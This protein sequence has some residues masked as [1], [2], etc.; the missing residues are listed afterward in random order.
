MHILFVHSDGFIIK[1]F[2]FLLP[3]HRWCGGGGKCGGKWAF[4]DVCE[5]IQVEKKVLPLYTFSRRKAERET[6]THALPLIPACKAV[7]RP[8]MAPGPET[9]G[10]EEKID[11][12]KRYWIFG[13]THNNADF[14]YSANTF[15]SILQLISHINSETLTWLWFIVRTWC[16]YCLCVFKPFHSFALFKA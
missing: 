4:R 16:Y 15:V 13:E 2:D 9:E 3:S 7:P 11:R 12:R 1:E 8:C 6:Q 5:Q 14:N 10:A